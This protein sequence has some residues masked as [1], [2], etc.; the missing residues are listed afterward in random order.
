MATN[1]LKSQGVALKRGDGGGTEVFTTIGE[2]FSIT[3][4]GGSATVIDATHFQSTAKE[5]IMGLPD[6]GQVSLEMNLDPT[7]AEQ[8]GLRS[9]RDAQTLR[10]FQLVL[11]DGGS[12]T[13][14][15]SAYV[16][17]FSI[18]MAVDDKITASVTLEISGSAT[19]A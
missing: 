3:G 5:K 9:D 14:S 13:I 4:P 6:E 17:T 2:V 16:M 12:T 11:T 19:W 18:S 10:N 15:F 1:A 8:T 7:D